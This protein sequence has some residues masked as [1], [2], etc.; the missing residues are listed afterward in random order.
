[1]RIRIAMALALALAATVGCGGQPRVR[2]MPADGVVVAFGDSLTHGTGAEPGESYPSRLAAR[3]GRKVINAG[4]P[5][6]LSSQGL[7]RLPAV[8]SAHRP[9]LVV[10]CHGGNDLLSGAAE[11]DVAANITSMAMQVRA[12]GATPV[13]VGVPRPGLLMKIPGFYAEVAAETGAPYEGRIMRVVLSD[14]SLRSDPIHPNAEGYELI[15]EALELV[16]AE[17]GAL[18][19]PDR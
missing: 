14:R 19:T 10:I 8:L 1:M 18:A 16:L 15:A 2:P 12:H 9:A 13:I 4:V 3:I 5:G 17:S 6:E 7:A 11:R